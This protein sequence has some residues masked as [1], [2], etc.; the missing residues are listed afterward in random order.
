MHIMVNMKTLQTR[1]REYRLINNLT[2]RELAERIG[3]P[4]T[5]LHAIVKRGQNPSEL[6]MYQIK[7]SLPSLFVDSGGGQSADSDAD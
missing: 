7:K 1:L 3:I 2:F 4:L 6:T 5:T